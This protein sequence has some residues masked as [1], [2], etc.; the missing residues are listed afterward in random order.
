MRIV[1][2]RIKYIVFSLLIIATGL[3]FMAINASSGNGAFNLDVDF[4]GG[5]AINFDVGTEFSND[6]ILQIIKEN[7]ELTS[8]QIQKIV[9]TNEVS[10]KI[11]NI[12]QETRIKLIDAFKAKYGEQVAGGEI[13]D[14]SPTVSSEM[15]KS[16][17]LAFVVA[18][19]AI[20]LYV[21]LRFRDLRTGGS[22][23]IALVHDGLIVIAAYAILRIPVNNAF[24]AAILT[25]LGYSINATIVVFDRVRENKRI[26]RKRDNAELINISVKQTL[27]RSI[28]TS[29]TTLITISALYIMGVS[30]IRDFA[31][32]IIIGIICGTYSSVCLAGSTWF[33]LSEKKAR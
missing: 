9:G 7:T 29:L 13:R 33:M 21:S 20:L 26:A 15:Q 27:T 8:A 24:I 5:T 25:V 14:I 12:D 22:A 18:S 16:A 6:D 3:V 2:N 11:K 19:V 30:S 4:T 32:P 23:I 17:V 1:E 10:I 28:Y 31:L